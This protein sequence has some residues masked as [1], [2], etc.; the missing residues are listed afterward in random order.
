[1]KVLAEMEG[2]GQT[3]GGSRVNPRREKCKIAS[4]ML[5]GNL[6]FPRNCRLLLLQ[7]ATT[8]ATMCAGCWRLHT[9]SWKVLRMYCY[10]HNHLCS[11]FCFACFGD[12]TLVTF[13][14]VWVFFWDQVV[15]STVAGSFVRY[16]SV[17]SAQKAGDMGMGFGMCCMGARARG[18][19][20]AATLNSD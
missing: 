10:C 3:Q 15:S 19:A 4:I 18:R 14:G 6:S 13:V 20:S 2:R 17:R 5:R 7:S 8:Y 9:T 1:M 11:T 12:T 16:Y